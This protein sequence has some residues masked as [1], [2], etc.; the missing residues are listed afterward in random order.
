MRLGDFPQGPEFRQ[1]NELFHDGGWNGEPGSPSPGRRQTAQS[2]VATKCGTYG[3]ALNRITN[4][5]QH[6]VTNRIRLGDALA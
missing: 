4:R 1:V 5:F 2:M 6:R 3:I